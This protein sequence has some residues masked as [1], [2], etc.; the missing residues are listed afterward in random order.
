MSK[1]FH[2]D[3]VSMPKWSETSQGFLR[4]PAA[5]TRV[6]VFDYRLPDGTVRKELRPPEE[7]FKKE[8]LETLEGA[9]VT[10]AE[11][12]TDGIMINPENVGK[13]EIGSV[14]DQVEVNNGHVMAKVTIKK[15]DAIDLIKNGERKDVSCGYYCRLD[16]TPGSWNGE[17]YDAVQRDI[18]YNHASIGPEN[19]GRAGSSVGLR[20]DSQDVALQ[21]EPQN[22]EIKGMAETSLKIDGVELKL[23]STQAGVI[24]KALQNREAQ[25][26]K[27]EELKGKH[28][29]AVADLKK[30]EAK[31]A[32]L[33]K[34]ERLDSLVKARA[35]LIAR[36]GLFTKESFDGKSDREIKEL[37]IK[38]AAPEIK[39][40]S[41]SEEY[42]DGVFA[43]LKTPEA[44][45]KA[46]PKAD[47]LAA[48]QAAAG[49][50][51]KPQERLD[52]DQA[53][54]AM[55]LRHQNAWKSGE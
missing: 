11:P 41:K 37:A 52:A 30:A 34:P 10:D 25:I 46:E 36:A 1:I 50:I 19:W 54:A 49:G 38:E 32:D 14:S 6:G 21:I 42:I 33:E 48:A 51:Q 31:I 20:L 53:R 4:G 45:P 47:A 16:M 5:L 24:D 23:D 39:L 17:K 44:E 43:T 28:D 40:D 8:S 26:K 7:V 35:E 12:H 13:Y 9:P 15:K 22:M 2:F 27:F 29:A 55:I 3:K 18:V